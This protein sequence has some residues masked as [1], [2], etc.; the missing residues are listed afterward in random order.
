MPKFILDQ[1]VYCADVEHNI[2]IESKITGIYHCFRP[3]GYSYSLA[4]DAQQIYSEENL[5]I[6][7]RDCFYEKIIDHREQYLVDK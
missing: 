7:L 4:Y 3:A 1:I 5:F 2:I 6:S